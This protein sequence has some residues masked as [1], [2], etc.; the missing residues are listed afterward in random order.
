MTVRGA[1]AIGLVGGWGVVLALKEAV[2]KKLNR[3]RFVKFIKEACREIVSSRPTA[4]NLSYVVYR[5]QNI[6][7]REKDFIVD[8]LYNLTVDEMKKLEEENRNS[9]VKIVEFG[10]QLLK[11]DSIVLTHC[12]TGA[13]A[14]GDIGTA[15]GIIIEG[16]KRGKV[17]HI[18]VDETRPYLQG[19]RLTMLELISAGVPCS[20]ITDNMAAYVVKQKGV[21]CIIVGADRI[22]K[23]GDTANK[24]GTYNLAIIARY[25]QIPFYVAAPFSSIDTQISS[26]EQIKIEQRSDKEVKYINSTLITL[27][28][29][30][31]LHPAFDITPAELITAIITDQGIFQYPYRF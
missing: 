2:K 19:A 30:D 27:K 12:N 29:A 8:K 28:N 17:K 21:D 24:I 16:Y 22:A 31:V 3:D 10:L 25:H 26:G 13:L 5:L 9:M 23:N 6:I 15:L 4:Y 7:F 18:Y 14:C 1:P 20:L 11:N